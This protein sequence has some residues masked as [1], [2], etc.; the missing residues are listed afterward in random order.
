MIIMEKKNQGG[1]AV[2]AKKEGLSW[3]FQQ[4]VC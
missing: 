4:G 3:F 2:S 1:K